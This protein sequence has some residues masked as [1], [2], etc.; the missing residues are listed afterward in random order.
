M[1]VPP[2]KIRPERLPLWLL[3]LALSTLFLFSFDKGYFHR[4]GYIDKD[5]AKYLAMAENL[6]PSHGFQRDE[7]GPVRGD[8]GVPR[9]GLS[10]RKRVDTL[11]RHGSR[12]PRRRLLRY[13]GPRGERRPAHARGTNRCFLY[14]SAGMDD[15]VELYRTT[16]QR[17]VSREPAARSHFDVYLRDRT[18]FHVREPCVR[19]DARYRVFANVFPE[20]RR[21]CPDGTAATPGS[22]LGRIPRLESRDTGEPVA[23]AVNPP[24]L[25]RIWREP[26]DIVD[27]RGSCR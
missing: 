15:L 3:L 24:V 4:T 18:L 7:H 22:P 27:P 6:S 1:P 10:C 23:P 16:Y 25:H 21:T 11:P 8:A 20:D 9:H 5:T 2:P 17:V 19:E 12:G 26:A 14:D 13:P